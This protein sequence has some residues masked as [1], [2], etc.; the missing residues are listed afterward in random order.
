MHMRANYT[1]IILGFVSLPL[2]TG[3]GSK[4]NAAP[5]VK[6][7]SK[8]VEAPPALPPEPPKAKPV[9][10][11]SGD[12]FRDP[13][14]PAGQSSSYQ[15][16]AVFEPQRAT[17]KAIIHGDH[18]KTAVVSVGSNGVYFIKDGHIFDVMGKPSEGFKAQVFEDRVVIHGEADTTYEI[19]MRN[20]GQEE[21]P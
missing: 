17:L 9:Y 12:R 8:A 20:E 19:K 11:Y 5:V 10:V 13:F 4:K 16:D 14:M 6:E 7:A 21:K 1:F 15:P 3:C 2:M 18:Y